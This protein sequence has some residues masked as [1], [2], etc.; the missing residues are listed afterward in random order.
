MAVPPF[1]DR[2]AQR[3]V[4]QLLSE[5]IEPLLHRG[6]FGYRPRISRRQARHAIESAYAA[7]Y[8]WV[9][10]SDIEDFFDSVDWQHVRHRLCALFRDDPV[11]RTVLAWMAAP[12]W[13]AG[14][15]L[16]RTE[17][18]PQGAPLSPLMANLVLDDFDHDVEGAGLRMV[19]F[20]DDFVI[21]CK[22][23]EE[24]EAAAKAVRASLAQ[25]GLSLNAEKTRVVSFEQG[26]RYL[27]YLFV[28]G[29]TLD[30]PRRAQKDPPMNPALPQSD[31]TNLGVPPKSWLA[32]ERGVHPLAPSVSAA[33]APQPQPKARIG[34]AVAAPAPAVRIPAAVPEKLTLILAGEPYSLS[35]DNAQLIVER[36]HAEIARHPWGHLA[37]VV[38]V[39]PHHMT[40]PALRAAMRAGVPVHFASAGGLPG[41]RQRRTPPCRLGAVARAKP[42]LH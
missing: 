18:L 34:D 8:R 3:A 15:T 14:E 25:I 35:T 24:A 29:L 20:A 41:F 37:G 40:L 38:L 21:L 13:F 6:S 32:V 27:G 10:E 2:V 33:S 36:D 30:A 1:W 17:G 12:V 16:P 7:G 11:V 31:A 9:F 19:R 22:S 26:F 28:N 5:A 42:S 39:G 4:F 23:R